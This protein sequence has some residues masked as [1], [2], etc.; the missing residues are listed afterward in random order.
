MKAL[1]IA[2]EASGD[3]HASHLIHSLKRI[4]P[5]I[6]FSGIGGERMKKEGVRIIYPAERI[7]VVGFSEIISKISN[8]KESRREISK[9]IRKNRFDFA[10]TVDF[11]GFN[12]PTAKY[13]HNNN[14]PVFYFITPQAWAWGRWRI[15]Y[16]SKYY[17]HLFV[18]YPFEENFFRK[19]GITA[20]YLGNPLVDIVK[21]PGKLIEEDL[22]KGRPFVAILP[23][24]RESEIKRLLVPILKA[25]RLFLE[26]HP[27]SS[28]GVAL[29]DEKLLPLVKNTG[30]NLLV[31]IS[32]FCG[33]TYDILNLCDL[34]IVSSGTA[35]I[36]AGIFK[37][38]MVI[39]YKLS[40][41]SWMI[42]KLLVK[43]K[44]FGLINLIL[45]EKIVP[46]LIQKE[47]NPKRIARELEKAYT[48]RDRISKRLGELKSKLGKEG[49]YDRIAHSLLSMV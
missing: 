36:E 21:P 6:K 10:V 3:L 13:L 22:P 37:T 18:I 47:V 38:P 41:L 8:L 25:Y 27:K 16:L 35:T 2:G 30:K 28:A 32:V 44:Y 48:N 42:A 14:I 26:K 9:C 12:I 1:F 23:G 4:K 33:K 17:K 45:S 5:E 49:S 31:D 40:L 20:T 7:S 24:S 11:P 34:A 29:H 43:V 39:V 19:E 15:K 46:E